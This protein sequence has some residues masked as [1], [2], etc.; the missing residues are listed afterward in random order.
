MVDA[1]DTEYIEDD[2]VTY[3]P[4]ME[5]LVDD[6]GKE[7][8]RNATWI[9]GAYR[10]NFTFGVRIR[11]PPFSLVFAFRRTLSQAISVCVLCFRRS[12]AWSQLR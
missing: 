8:I 3:Y 2:L 1:D 5:I 4:S 12:S 7:I 9:S 11:P 6:I 10:R